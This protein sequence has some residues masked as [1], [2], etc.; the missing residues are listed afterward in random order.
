MQ[1]TAGPRQ[2]RLATCSPRP[3]NPKP[4]PFLPATGAAAVFI[5]LSL[6]SETKAVT[7]HILEPPLTTK[8]LGAGSSPICGSM[9]DMRKWKVT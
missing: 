8:A 9:T 7:V 4:A 1:Q 6:V 2:A 5:S 3:L